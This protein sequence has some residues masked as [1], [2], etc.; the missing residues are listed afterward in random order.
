MSNIHLPW[1][2]KGY[3]EF[4]KE[5]PRGLVIGRLARLVG[6]NKSSFYHYFADVRSF[7][8]DL[9]SF[10]LEQAETII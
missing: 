2:E 7:Q 9:L 8:E 10:H 3:S 1:I 5:G 6:K 4:A